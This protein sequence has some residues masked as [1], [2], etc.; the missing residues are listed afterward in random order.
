MNNQDISMKP[1]NQVLISYELL[2]LIEWLAENEPEAIR[3]I[4][5]RALNNGFDEKIKNMDLNGVT[6]LNDISYLLS[7]LEGLIFEA[8]NEHSLNKILQKKLLPSMD[9]IDSTV[10]DEA[11]VKFSA[12][13][14]SSKINKSKDKDDPQDLLFKEIL[15]HWKPT[16][17]KTYN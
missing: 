14:A 7:T 12:E 6:D 16:N 13:K 15:K 2:A 4:I 1:E 10:C 3:K 11:L 9:K 17:K 5:N 8:I